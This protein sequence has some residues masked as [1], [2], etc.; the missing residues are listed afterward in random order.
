MRVLAMPAKDDMSSLLRVTWPAQALIDQ[1]A[2]IEI[3]DD[4]WLIREHSQTVIDVEDI[5]CDVLVLCRPK[6]RY[7]AQSIPILQAHGVAVVVDYDDDLTAVHKHNTAHAAFDPDHNAESNWR[8]ALECAHQADLVT[9]STPHLLDVYASHGRGRVLPNR[10]PTSRIP[11]PPTR[12]D[13]PVR[14]GWAGYIGT[15]PTDLTACDGAVAKVMRSRF[16]PFHVI[17]PAH[18]LIGRQLGVGRI[19]ATGVVDKDDWL[20]TIAATLDVGIAPAERSAFNL[21]KSC[22]KSIEGAAAGVA[23]VASPTP[24]NRRA[25]ANGLCLL[26]QDRRDWI[27]KLTLMLGD[28]QARAEQ[29][30]AAT[31]GLRHHLLEPAAG[32]WWDAWETART[33]HDENHRPASQLPVM[34]AERSE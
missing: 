18:P 14:L 12:E 4:P 3:S 16:D 33:N 20:P 27:R 8:W 26:A 9:V 7:V 31:A 22:L 15:H 1:G 19:R 2:D 13:G 25:A 24:D 5:E 32:D 17:G 23:M 30:E 6:H 29:V 34:A 28:D 10:L 11:I 21:G